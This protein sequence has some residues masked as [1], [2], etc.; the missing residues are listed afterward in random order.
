MSFLREPYPHHANYAGK[1]FS[2]PKG[3]DVISTMQLT[4]LTAVLKSFSPPKGIDVISTANSSETVSREEFQQLQVSV[5]RRGLMSFLPAARRSTC[6]SARR[7]SFSP[8]KGI[9][10]IST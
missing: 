7:L 9:D 5:P 6:V 3:I 2:P 8:P 4:A 1:C 10:V